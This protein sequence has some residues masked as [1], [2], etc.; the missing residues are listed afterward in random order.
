MAL[1]TRKP[2][3]VIH[4]SDQGSQN[5]SIAFGNRCKEMG[6]RPS[7]GTVGDAHYKAMAESFFASL[8]CDLIG[9]RSW[10]TNSEARLA[11]LPKL[12][13]STTHADPILG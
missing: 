4:H 5:T 1:M 6:V 8:E 13:V 2:L 12:N 7:M 9:R 10:K 3:S 11:V